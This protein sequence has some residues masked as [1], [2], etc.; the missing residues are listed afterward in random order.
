MQLDALI[1]KRRMVHSFQRTTPPPGLVDEILEAALHAPS[2]GFSQGFRLTVVDDWGRIQQ[3][4]KVAMKPEDPWLA[5]M[6]ESGPP[7]LAIATV[8]P[9]VYLERY[10]QP[11][12]GEAGLEAA[13]RW[14]VP[15]WWVDAGMAVMLILLTAVDRGL[16][17]WF[18]GVTKEQ[19]DV[20]RRELEIPAAHEL[21]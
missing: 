7:I 6:L 14:P 4:L 16:G 5:R 8:S 18:Y 17:G 10:S 12:K 2:A 21:V 11:D 3:L 1:R 20:F 19:E 13:D 15:Y 9:A